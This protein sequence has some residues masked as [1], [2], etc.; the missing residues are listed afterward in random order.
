[1]GSFHLA[2]SRCF[3]RYIFPG[4]PSM[5]SRQ[6]SMNISGEL[7]RS[8]GF[9][10]GRWVSASSTF[11][12]LD[13]ATGQELAQVSDCGPQQAQE[14]VSAAYK[15]FHSWKTQTAK[16]NKQQVPFQ[17][18]VFLQLNT[19]ES[20]KVLTLYWRGYVQLFMSM[21]VYAAFTWGNHPVAITSFPT[22]EVRR[23]KW[24][25]KSGFCLL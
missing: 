8:Q 5:L 3:V 19:W 10:N 17:T 21:K 13:P 24:E 23:V 22:R 1:M 9:I 7:L 18:S 11:P 12:V 16:V 14:A 6:Y 25:R 4:L 20:C 2:N 15:A